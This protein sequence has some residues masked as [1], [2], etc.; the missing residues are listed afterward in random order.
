MLFIVYHEELLFEKILSILKGLFSGSHLWGL[1]CMQK[2]LNMEHAYLNTQGRRN[3][4]QYGGAME[5]SKVL[6]ATILN[7]RRSRMAKT[8]TFWL[9]WQSFN[10]LCFKTLCFFPL[11]LFFLFVTQKK[12]GAGMRHLPGPPS[13]AGPEYLSKCFVNPAAP[14]VLQISN[15]S[16]KILESVSIF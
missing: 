7:S 3:G 1:V 13:V 6:S 12:G 5:H 9:W 8:A 11:F 15:L 10:S 16:G 14:D 4:F 2:G